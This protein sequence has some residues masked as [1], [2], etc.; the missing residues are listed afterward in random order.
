LSEQSFDGNSTLLILK[1]E[2]MK[3]VYIKPTLLKS[4]MS[5]QTVTATLPISLKKVG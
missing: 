5:L 4:Q 2:A 1:E 3:R